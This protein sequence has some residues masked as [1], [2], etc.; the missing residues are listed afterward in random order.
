MRTL[1]QAV[2]I[3]DLSRPLNLEWIGSG[4]KLNL[5]PQ[6]LMGAMN[7]LCSHFLLVNPV[8]LKPPG[9]ASVAY[10]QSVLTDRGHGW[11]W[12][13]SSLNTQTTCEGK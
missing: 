2:R 11:I 6:P 10:N 8:L 9:S 3:A 12:A 7:S 5:G 4:W 13:L 1:N